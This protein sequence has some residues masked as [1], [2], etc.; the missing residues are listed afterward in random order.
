MSVITKRSIRVPT[1]HTG[2]PEH[3]L[4]MVIAAV[5]ASVAV[6]AVWGGA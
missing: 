4:A 6:F 5:V 2:P 1:L 3:L